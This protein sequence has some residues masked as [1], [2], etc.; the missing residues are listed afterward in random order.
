MYTKCQGVGEDTCLAKDPLESDIISILEMMQHCVQRSHE[1]RNYLTIV[2]PENNG[3]VIE[4]LL[5]H[6]N[7]HFQVHRIFVQEITEFC[8]T[9]RTYFQCLWEKMLTI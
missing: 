9:R 7:V 6:S 8:T 4:L 2:K 5:W 1:R 3:E